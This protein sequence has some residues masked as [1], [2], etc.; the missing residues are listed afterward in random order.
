VAAVMGGYAPP[1][2]HQSARVPTPAAHGGR[3]QQDGHGRET[4]TGD[5]EP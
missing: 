5:D 1:P 3:D 4:L 2:R